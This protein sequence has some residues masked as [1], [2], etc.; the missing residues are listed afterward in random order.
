LGEIEDVSQ[1]KGPPVADGPVV[2]VCADDSIEE[3]R[4]FGRGPLGSTSYRIWFWSFAVFFA[5]VGL[6]L[7]GRHLS[8]RSFWLLALLVYLSLACNFFPLPTLWI[9][10]AAGSFSGA[11]PWTVAFVAAVGTCIANLNDY[12]LL[13]FLLGYPKFARLKKLR[14]YK[15]AVRWF[16]KA[17]FLMILA[18]NLLPIPIDLIRPLAIYSR[19]GRV[20]FTLAGF[21]GRFPRYLVIAYVGRELP[22]TWD[23]VLVVLVVTTMVPLINVLTALV[24]RGRASKKGVSDKLQEGAST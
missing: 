18:A 21:A 20:H 19:Y 5:V 17:P 9:V 10:L 11:A 14:F 6:S 3:P 22:L 24:R 12:H 4:R 13:S 23:I 1:G 7:G 2:G 16:G 15:G 8:D